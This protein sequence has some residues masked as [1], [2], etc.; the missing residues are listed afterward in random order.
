MVDFRTRIKRPCLGR[1]SY[2]YLASDYAECV[3]RTSTQANVGYVNTHGLSKGGATL[4]EKSSKY[5]RPRIA[6]AGYR[7]DD[8]VSTIRGYVG[9]L[10]PDR[11]VPRDG[12]SNLAWALSGV[13]EEIR[14]VSI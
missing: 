1:R 12:F 8:E 2:F 6:S 7:K 13:E 5:I 11:P 3:S 4:D 10:R 14:S 9:P